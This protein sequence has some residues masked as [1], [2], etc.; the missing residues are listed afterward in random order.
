MKNII[1]IIF[2]FITIPLLA[3]NFNSVMAINDL[4]DKKTATFEDAVFMFMLQ[5]KKNPVN[6]ATNMKILDK[7]GITSGF[8]YKKDQPLRRGIVSKMIAR[9]LKL[10]DNLFYL[11]SGSERYAF[12]ACVAHGIMDENNSEW[13]KLSGEELIEIMSYLSNENK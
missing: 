11:M 7:E 10:K 5:T 13:D 9:Y 3:Q 1:I 4:A 6:F 12:R 2:L 8:K